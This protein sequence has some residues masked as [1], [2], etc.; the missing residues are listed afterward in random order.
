MMLMA[1]C[2]LHFVVFQQIIGLFLFANTCSSAIYTV[3][4]RAGIST[5]CTTVGKFLQWLS[6]STQESVHGSAQSRVF[7]L[8]YDN[9]NRMQRAWDPELGQKDTVLSGTAA[10]FV[11]IKDCNV[12]KA[13]DPSQWF[14]VNEP[15]WEVRCLGDIYWYQPVQVMKFMAS[16]RILDLVDN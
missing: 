4:N 5:S 11:E 8:I 10:T 2:N 13:L 1:A 3:L 15:F 7:L 14:P 16:A 9:I 6:Q 12:E